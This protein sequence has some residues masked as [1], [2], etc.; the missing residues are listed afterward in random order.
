MIE[1]KDKVWGHEEWLVNT[2]LYCAKYL[3]LEQG[4]ECSLHYHKN[5]DETFYVL[6]GSV[7]IDIHGGTLKLLPGQSVRVR[8]G[9]KHRFRSITKTSKILEISTHH[10]EDDSYRI[11]PSREIKKDD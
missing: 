9:T 5:K 7:E 1:W 8:P 6:D 11:E 4:Y 3:I 2:N 10:E